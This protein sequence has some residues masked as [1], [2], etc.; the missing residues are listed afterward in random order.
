MALTYSYLPGLKTGAGLGYPVVMRDG[1]LNVGDYVIQMEV[2]DST[3]LAIGDIIMAE[4][5]AS[6][7]LD[8]TGDRAI[9]AFAIVLDSVRNKSILEAAGTAV[10]KAAQFADGDKIDILLL[11]PGMILSVKCDGTTVVAVGSKMTCAAGGTT[12]VMANSATDE[13]AC[14]IGYSLTMAAGTATTAGYIALMVK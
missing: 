14:L 11:V 13:P 8:A 10:S 9:T 12:D 2:K 6:L 1:G 5:A 7:E 3:E 4:S